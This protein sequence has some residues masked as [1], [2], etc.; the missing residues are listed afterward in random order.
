MRNKALFI[1]A[2]IVAFILCSTA[3]LYYHEWFF[4]YYGTVVD[5][6]E[7]T[8]SVVIPRTQLQTIALV[9]IGLLVLIVIAT[10]LA[11]FVWSIPEW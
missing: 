4:N 6:P 10:I 8:H 5:V 1:V 2:F 9:I 3:A 7:E 11:A